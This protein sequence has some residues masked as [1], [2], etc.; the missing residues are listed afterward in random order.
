[1]NFDRLVT[2][3]QQ[4]NDFLQQS[5]VKAVNTHLTFR[6]WLIGFHIV[7]FQQNGSDRADYGTK[8]LENIAKKISVKGLT[9]PELSRCR[10]FY[11]VYPQIL[12]LITQE[13]KNVL[14][15]EFLVE[16]VILGSATQELIEIFKCYFFRGKGSKRY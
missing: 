6:N 16:K 7:E 11:N 15:P 1:M 2:R 4:T 10:Q 14:P 9:T 13:F 8:L 5:A 3:I 12:G